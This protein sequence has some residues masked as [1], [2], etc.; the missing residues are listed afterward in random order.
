MVGDAHV[1]CLDEEQVG[2][3]LYRWHQAAAGNALAEHFRVYVDEVDRRLLWVFFG[4][5]EGAG[6]FLVSCGFFEDTAIDSVGQH[7]ADRELLAAEDG[8]ANRAGQP[9]E[10]LRNCDCRLA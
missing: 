1:D 10:L 8:D 4:A 5:E 6:I 3:T 2:L 9:C 7:L